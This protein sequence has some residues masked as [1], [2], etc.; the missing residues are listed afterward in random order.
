MFIIIIITLFYGLDAIYIDFQLREAVSKAWKRAISAA[1]S[2]KSRES[3]K[4]L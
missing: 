3:T 1:F 4:E 2:F